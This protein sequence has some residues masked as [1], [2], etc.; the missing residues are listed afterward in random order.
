[1]LCASF[2]APFMR[3]GVGTATNLAFSLWDVKGGKGKSTAL[4]AAAGVW[5]D[6]HRI[7][8]TKSDTPASRFQKFSVYKNLPIFC[9][10]ITNINDTALS[11]LIYDI[12]NGREKSRSTSSGTDLAKSG[13]WNTIAMFTSNKSLYEALH[14]QRVQS[15]ATCM[16][17]IEYQC[18]F[19]DYTGTDT[20]RYITEVSKL[21]YEHFGQAGPEFM[22]CVLSDFDVNITHIR[23]FA[24]TFVAKY[25]RTSDERFWMYGLGFSLGAGALAYQYGFLP[26]DIAGW[27]MPWIINKLLPY[28]RRILKGKGFS[29]EDIFTHYLDDNL[30][31]TLTVECA[32]RPNDKKDMN[33]ITAMDKYI[34]SYPS[35]AL[36]I[37]HEFDTHTIY[38]STKHFKDWCTTNNVSLT[39]LLQDLT[40][41]GIYKNV[42]TQV[43]LG[44]G[45]KALPRTR[46]MSYEFVCPEELVG[47]ETK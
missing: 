17:L 44:Q 30:K 29:A 3:Y 42:Q 12:V 22:K 23:K 25:S 15:D 20:H 16:R 18:D 2:A 36:H 4:A 6:P 37:R 9:D 1:M 47:Y 8:Q 34:I 26:Y 14:S 41:L 38:V 11:D 19:Q 10:E 43:S 40:R 31:S 39:A 27:L 32:R 5:G 28:L 33:V 13:T 46:I 35:N 21:I 7:L 24:E 45:V